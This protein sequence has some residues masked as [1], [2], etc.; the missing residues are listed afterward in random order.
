MRGAVGIGIASLAAVT[1][2]IASVPT[3]ITEQSWEGW[4]WWSAFGVLAT[5]ATEADGV[6]AFST[7]AEFELDSKAMRKFGEDMAFFT[8]I[9]VVETGTASISVS[10]DTRML[11]ALP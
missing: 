11:F 7:V 4:L 6:N 5:T 8:A 1:A 10:H 3:P 9:E 2:G